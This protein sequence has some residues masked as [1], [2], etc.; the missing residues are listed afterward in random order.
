[1]V[2]AGVAWCVALL[3]W[4]QQGVDEALALWSAGLD[5]EGLTI[6]LAR[7]AS[8]YGM[9]TMCAILLAGLVASVRG[10]SWR[11]LRAI[12]LLTLLSFGISGIAG[13]LLKEA[14]DRLRPPFVYPE[15]SVAASG[16]TSSS[17][18]SGHST[19][20]V[21]LALPFLLFVTGWRGRRG[22]VKCALA[23]LALSVCTSRVVLGAHFL[24][25]V[26]GGLAMALS[27]LPFAVLASNAILGAMTPSDMD[28]AGRIWIGV[29]VVLIFIMWML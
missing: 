16:F 25:D 29:Y 23:G 1:L 27:G 14:V 11:P 3:L 2:A 20:A 13:D 26:V 18:P 10:E 24:S 22:L 17:F 4:S 12:Y 28:R 7:L 21:A 5:E 8:R 19:K 15:L 6:A 9:A